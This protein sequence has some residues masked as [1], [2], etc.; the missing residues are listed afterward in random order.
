MQ[1]LDNRVLIKTL[2]DNIT[3]GGIHLPESRKHRYTEHGVVMAIG[4][5][6]ELKDGTRAISQLAEGDHVIIPY[7][8]VGVD[9]TIN[10]V[11]YRILREADI[12]AK[13]EDEEENK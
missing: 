3:S 11:Q 6:K 2:K 4:P 13:V 5:G 9:V 12:L 7:K 8:H 1:M 10:R